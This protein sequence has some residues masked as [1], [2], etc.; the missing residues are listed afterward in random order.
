MCKGTVQTVEGGRGERVPIRFETYNIPKWSERRDGISVERDEPGKR[1]YWGLPRDQ[2]DRG[3]LPA[4]FSRVQGCRDASAKPTPGQR[5][6]ILSI[7]PHLCSRG[8]TPVWRERH[9]MPAG[10]GGGAGTLW[11]V[12]ETWRR[13]WRINQGGR[14]WL[15]WG[16]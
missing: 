14:S 4:V 9:S 11:D 1:G 8:D 16:T 3:N 5:C 2:I 12:F 7:I 10:D 13:Q 15:L 6:N